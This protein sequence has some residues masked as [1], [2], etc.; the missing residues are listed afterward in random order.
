MNF[1]SDLLPQDNDYW[2]IFLLTIEKWNF[3]ALVSQLSS[4]GEFNEGLIQ[5]FSHKLSFFLE[6]N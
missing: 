5:A 3:F 2:A 4:F 6:Q 1:F